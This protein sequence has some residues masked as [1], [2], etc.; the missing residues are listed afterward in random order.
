VG[1]MPVRHARGLYPLDVSDRTGERDARSLDE[2]WAFSLRAGCFSSF[3]RSWLGCRGLCHGWQQA[4]AWER[5]V[6]SGVALV[7]ERWSGA[8]SDGIGGARGRVGSIAERSFSRAGVRVGWASLDGGACF[9]AGVM[10]TQQW[11]GPGAVKRNAGSQRRTPRAHRTLLARVWRLNRHRGRRA[12]VNGRGPYLRDVNESR[13]EFPTSS[14]TTV[15]SGVAV[16]VSVVVVV[17]VVVV[18]PDEFQ[19]DSMKMG[20][21]HA[22][23]GRV[24]GAPRIRLFSPFPSTGFARCRCRWSWSLVV[25]RR[26][27]LV[28]VGRLVLMCLV[29]GRV[30]VVGAV[31]G[32][33]RSVREWNREMEHLLSSAP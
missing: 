24:V 22:P 7:G 20:D 33:K 18:L 13:H 31:V 23:E 21:E 15:V 27:S 2:E 1:V 4:F 12:H 6:V 10:V 14:T 32:R 11:S 19:R 29:V 28:V 30:V 25:S 3:G 26:W 5:V 9:E 8:F 16:V 17:V